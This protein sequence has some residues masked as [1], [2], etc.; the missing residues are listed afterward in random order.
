MA[1]KWDVPG[2]RGADKL[3]TNLRANLAEAVLFRRLATL[4]TDLPVGTV[5]DW[6]WHGPTPGFAEVCDKLGAPQLARRA[7]ALAKRR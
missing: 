6:C 3:A 5:D 4:E 2:L 7:E 1:G